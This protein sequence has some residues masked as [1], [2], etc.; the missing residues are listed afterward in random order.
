VSELDARL[1]ELEGVLL[2][3]QS[4]AANA[5]DSEP[6]MSE[7]LHDELVQPIDRA[8]ANLRALQGEYPL[9]ESS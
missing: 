8:L 3:A 6:E 5:R 1:F 2:D 4:R 7:Q 9:C